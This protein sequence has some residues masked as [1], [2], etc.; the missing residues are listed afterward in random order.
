MV[1]DSVV[2]RVRVGVARL[3][4][5][6]IDRSHSQKPSST[7][8][9]GDVDRV[10][11]APVSQ[12]AGVAHVHAGLPGQIELASGGEL[13]AQLGTLVAGSVE[14]ELLHGHG[15]EDSA[16]KVRGGRSGVRFWYNRPSFYPESSSAATP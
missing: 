10:A 9:P 12:P 15:I 8:G 7:L 16:W 2:A 5:E 13:G 6:Q 3:V 1:A 4:G 14:G 11:N